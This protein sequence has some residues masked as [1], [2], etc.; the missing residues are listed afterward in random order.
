MHLTRILQ[1][2]EDDCGLRSWILIGRSVAAK[3]LEIGYEIFCRS[4]RPD[5]SSIIHFDGLKRN[6]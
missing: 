2:P 5:R 1:E 6:E 4:E 3:E